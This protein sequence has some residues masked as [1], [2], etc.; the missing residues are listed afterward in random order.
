MT[1]L[2]PES[3]AYHFF[4]RNTAALKARS[5]D[6]KG[7]CLRRSLARRQSNERAGSHDASSRNCSMA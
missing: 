2:A 3:A 5:T 1:G 6:D 7:A 4:A